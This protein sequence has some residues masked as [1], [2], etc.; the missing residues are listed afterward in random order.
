MPIYENTKNIPVVINNTTFKF[1]EPVET[2][3]VIDLDKYPQ[4]IK[5]SDDPI[6]CPIIF[7]TDVASGANVD[8]SKYV[9]DP[10]ASCIEILSKSGFSKVAFN[11]TGTFEAGITEN[12]PLVLYNPSNFYKVFCTSGS[13]FIEVW[14]SFAHRLNTL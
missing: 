9:T 1:L 4:L 2:T 12:N 13:V 3:F 14:K 10:E 8:L 11:K 6:Y 5:K 7:S